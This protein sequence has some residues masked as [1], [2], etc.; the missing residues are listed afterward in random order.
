MKR[1]E[2]ID[3]L[4]NSGNLPHTTVSDA[5]DCILATLSES[6]SRGQRIEIRGF[7]SFKVK[8]RPARLA[9]NPKTGENLPIDKKTKVAFKASGLLC[10]RLNKESD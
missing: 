3:E 7:G 6:L 2:L 1:S 9:R 4:Y 5:V 10:A 8:E